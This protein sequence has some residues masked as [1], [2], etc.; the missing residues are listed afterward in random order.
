MALQIIQLSCQ[1]HSRS[2]VI[3]PCM[4]A[5]Q[6]VSKSNHVEFTRFVLLAVKRRSKN[7][8]AF[9]CFVVMCNK[10]IIRFSVCYIQNNQGLGKVYELKLRAEAYNPTLTLIILDITKTESNNCLMLVVSPTIRHI[11]LINR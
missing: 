2:P 1:G 8:I 9:F 10:T 7:M 3:P 5:V 4:T 11:E 6:L